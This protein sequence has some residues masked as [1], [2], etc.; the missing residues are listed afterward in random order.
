MNELETE[1]NK[2]RYELSVTIPEELRCAVESG[3]LLEN[4]EYSEILSRQSVLSLRLSQLVRRLNESTAIEIHKI[5]KDRIGI[6]SKVTLACTTTHQQSL[7]K[8]VGSE[9]SD[10]SKLEFEEITL[11]SPIGK[12]IVNKTT[13]DEIKVYTPSGVKHYKIVNF[14]TIHEQ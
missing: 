11:K 12:N 13:G 3:D 9:I 6:G 5:P 10:N 14:H 8:L 7:V 1:I 4:G 2:I